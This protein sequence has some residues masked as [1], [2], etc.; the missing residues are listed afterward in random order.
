MILGLRTISSLLPIA[1][2]L[3][4]SLTGPKCERVGAFR[5]RHN[6]LAIATSAD[7]QARTGLSE[8]T[9]IS[10]PARLKVHLDLLKS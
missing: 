9:G 6:D 5:L 7:G 1:S 10:M 8:E 4:N 2:R 3:V